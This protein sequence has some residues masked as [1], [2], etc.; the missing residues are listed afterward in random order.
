VT[1]ESVFKNQG[2]G[3]QVVFTVI[4]F[5]LYTVWWFYKTGKTID[6][7]TNQSATPIFAFVPFANIILMW[8]VSKGAEAFNEQGAMPVF[9]LFLFFPIISWYWVQSGI[10]QVASR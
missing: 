5:G 8:Q 4:T 10:N 1:D 6:R 7:G 9:L 2:L 3:I